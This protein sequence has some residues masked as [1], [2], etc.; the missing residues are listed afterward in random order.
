MFKIS[1]YYVSQK[2]VL[3]RIELYTEQ[4]EIIVNNK[5]KFKYSIN[6]ENKYWFKF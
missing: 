1:W 2:I 3:Y 4:Y 6:I 5:C